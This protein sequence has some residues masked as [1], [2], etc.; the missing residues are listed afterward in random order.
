MILVSFLVNRIARLMQFAMTKTPDLETKP[1]YSNTTPASL[2]AH[3]FPEFSSSGL[4]QDSS[5]QATMK[6]K[7]NNTQG[8]SSQLISRGLPK[9]PISQ[10]MDNGDLETDGD[11]PS[12]QHKAPV[13]VAGVSKAVFDNI[14][15]ENNRLKKSL[16]EL[17][18]RENS[19]VKLFLV[20]LFFISNCQLIGGCC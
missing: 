12:G 2:V 20:R 8:N 13:V 3:P 16:Q 15:K 6:E 19:N 7:D 18:Q 17:L 9:N 14:V 4:S 10:Y 11:Q 1:G 5:R